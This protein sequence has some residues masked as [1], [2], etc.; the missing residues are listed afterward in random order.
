VHSPGG[1]NIQLFKDYSASKTGLSHLK[2][3]NMINVPD[4]IKN[5]LNNLRLPAFVSSGDDKGKY[6][7]LLSVIAAEKDDK[8]GKL[9]SLTTIFSIWNAM[10]GSGLLTIP[11]GYSNSGL[12][13]GISKQILFKY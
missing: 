9:G 12:A 11:W 8:T 7:S 3:E 10:V 6:F 5:E 1:T 4:E 13:L 2:K